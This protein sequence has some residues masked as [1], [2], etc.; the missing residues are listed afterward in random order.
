MMLLPD[1]KL[2]KRVYCGGLA[3]GLLSWL[4]PLI[5]LGLAPD[6]FDSTL[7]FHV[8][9]ALASTYFRGLNADEQAT[10]VLW[11]FCFLSYGWRR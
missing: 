1:A 9:N 8:N 4:G 5:A 10:I 2:P 3:L 7:A 11:V 6:F